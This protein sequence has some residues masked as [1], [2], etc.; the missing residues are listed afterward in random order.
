MLLLKLKAMKSPEGPQGWPVLRIRIRMF[1]SLLDPDLDLLV[2]GMDPDPE[3][4]I[5]KQK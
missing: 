1:L 3:P 5:I 2:R 4:F